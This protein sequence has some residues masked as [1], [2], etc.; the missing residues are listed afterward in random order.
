MASGKS[1]VAKKLARRL[2]IPVTDTDTLIENEQVKKIK[3]IFK[4][5]G[6][7]YFRKL[8]K[9]VARKVSGIKGAVVS[10]GGGIVLDAENRRIL[11]KCGT[12]FY[13]KT[14][15]ETILK[16]VKRTKV[17]ERPLL[18]SKSNL[19]D[20]IKRLLKIREKY[21]RACAHYVVDTSKMTVLEVVKKITNIVALSGFQ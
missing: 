4:L 2:K 9:D 20:E 17:S 7:P 1:V 18:M 10:T 21:Y 15:P 13:L 12:V 16:R 11:R 14:N 6:E 3:D 8:E 19:K 5:Q